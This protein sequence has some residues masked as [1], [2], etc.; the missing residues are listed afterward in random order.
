MVPSLFD[1]LKDSSTFLDVGRHGFLGNDTN[2]LFQRRHCECVV[3]DQTQGT[4]T[5]DEENKLT[6]VKVMRRVHR[7]DD[8]DLDLFLF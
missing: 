8:Q 5:K 2:S 4:N 1:G 6:D 3:S 7:G